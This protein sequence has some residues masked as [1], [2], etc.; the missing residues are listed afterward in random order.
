MRIS[1]VDFM[2]GHRRIYR[3]TTTVHGAVFAM[4]V[5][6][7]LIVLAAVPGRGQIVGYIFAP[8]W[9]IVT[10]R[11]WR[12]GV[13]IED[14]GVKVIGSLISKR[15]SWEEIDHFKVRPWQR[16][17]Y[18]GHVVL[19]SGRLVP[20]WGLGV[21]RLSKRRD[22]HHRLQVQEPIDRLTELLTSTGTVEYLHH[23][24]Q[25][26]TRLLTGEKGETVGAYTY[27]TYRNQ[28]G[29]TGTATTPL[30]YDG[31]YTSPDTVLIYLRNRVY[32]PTTAQF[33]TRDPLDPI[34]QEVYSYAQDDP[35][36]QADPT[37]RNGIFGRHRTKC[38][39]QRSGWRPWG[40]RKFTYEQS[41]LGSPNECG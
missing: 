6:V 38:Q 4:I 31:Q 25:G 32:D 33:L 39:P 37:G 18:H 27:G 41:L 14:G 23:D 24:E 3:S 20:I 21:A 10:W 26:S 36:N 17:P 1:G 28:T 5:L 8:L 11:A 7:G 30:G 12:W 13:A 22:E 9:L 40:C 35:L 15:F 16:E 34:T 19:K 29:H 2:E